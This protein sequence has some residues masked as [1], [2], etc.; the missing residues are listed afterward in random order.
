MDHVSPHQPDP[1]PGAEPER[2]FAV[3]VMAPGV[4]P[5]DELAEL[6]ELARTA[7]VGVIARLVQLRDQP[8]ARHDRV[9][10]V[11]EAHVLHLV[12]PLVRAVA[13][14]PGEGVFVDPQPGPVPHGLVGLGIRKAN[15]P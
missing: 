3:A 7:G 4:D 11:F 1:R 5:E 14:R 10:V 9:A 13:L 2:G 6:V 12:I 15:H 8:D